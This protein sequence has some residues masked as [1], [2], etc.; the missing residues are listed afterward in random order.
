MNNGD[1]TFTVDE[2]RAPAA[3]RH[4]PPESWYH[5]EGHLADLDNDGDLD[6]VLGQNRDIFPSTVNQF[7]VVLINDGAGDYPARIE[8]ARP[9]FNDGYTSVT[10][11]THFD[12]N[13]DGIPGPAVGAHAQRRWAAGRDSCSRGR[14]VQVLINRG[15]PSRVLL[16]RGPMSFGDETGHLDGRSKSDDGASSTRTANT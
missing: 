6:L 7:S 13:G 14:H 2:A 4:N 12:V 5:L 9:A 11:Q 16:R 8:L 3:L 10:G 1:G 15:T